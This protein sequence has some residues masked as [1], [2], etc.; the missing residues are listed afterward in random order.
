ML[1]LTG[2][3][4]SGKTHHALD[5]IREC[6][7]RG[8]A[9]ARLL[10]PTATMAEHLRN[11]LARD[12]YLVRTET[13]QTL[14]QFVDALA[15]SPRQVPEAALHHLVRASLEEVDPPAFRA[16]GSMP[17]FQAA[18]AELIEELDGT[19]ESPVQIGERV[20]R[21]HL[22]ADFAAPV[23]EIAAHVREAV[24]HRGME[25]RSDRLR[26]AGQRIGA[27][28]MF[29]VRDVL[30]DGFFRFTAIELDLIRALASAVDVTVTL[31]AWEGAAW[32][33]QALI[34]MGFREEVRFR[35]RQDPRRHLSSA[36]S[37][38]REAEEVA[39][40]VL[41][42]AARGRPFREIGVI[43][44]SRS[45]Y[46]PVLRRAF[47]R[48]AIPAR[49]YFAEPLASH[50]AVRRAAGIVDALLEGWDHEAVLATLRLH[51]ASAS[52]D[53]FEYG[54]L[55]NLPGHGLE[56][57]R[58]LARAS[59][60]EDLIDRLEETDGWRTS[61]ALPAVWAQRLSGLTAVLPS[62][63][64]EDEISHEQ[65]RL[66]RGHAAAE[67]SFRQA[68][69]SVSEVFGDEGVVS[70][71]D[72]WREAR[73][74][75]AATMLRIADNRRNV[76]H[77]M[78]VYEARQ[79]ELPVMFV[80]G[81]NERQFPVH[82]GENP[83]LGDS[84]REA[85]RD[86]GLDLRTSRDQ[87]N[88]E[89][90]LFELATTRATESLTLSYAAFDEGGE[91]K[92]PSFLLERF[93]EQTGLAIA[94]SV[95]VRPRPGRARPLPRSPVVRD[96]SLLERI[97]ATHS[98][99][100][101]SA[102]ERFLQCPFDFFSQKTLRLREMPVPPAER[103][104]ALLEGIIVHAVFAELFRRPEGFD[105][106]EQLF[107]RVFEDRCERAGVPPGYRKQ[108]ARLDLRDALSKFVA[109]NSLP[110]GL[111]SET[112][113]VFQFPLTAEVEVRGRMDRV[114]YH[115]GA[116]PVVIDYKYTRAH[117]LREYVRQNED[118]QRVQAGLYLMGLRERSQERPSG[119][120]F[121]AVRDGPSWKGWH[122]L[123]ELESVLHPVGEEEI[124]HLME[125]A[126]GAARAAA[127]RIR[128][129][130]IAPA[131][132]DAAM[133]TRCRHRDICRVETAPSV[134]VAGGDSR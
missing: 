119:M 61:D 21:R 54:V 16:V 50:P 35:R 88:E 103:L 80:C 74:V 133:C 87:D 67:G 47:E 125:T 63:A 49:F 110:R 77:V 29:G 31:P 19:G 59:S 55:E 83:L 3:T 56:R 132:E 100:S 128:A 72:F 86:E 89:R 97:A 10:T 79:W 28:G 90:F 7:Q 114:D 43:L 75:V 36:P 14:W 32:T 57:L 69:E 33:R 85:L 44:R 127:E 2:P 113:L 115:S 51:P 82:H 81:L 17:G 95:P 111:R 129:G 4:G 1:L 108:T 58:S 52:L 121:C 68:L 99:L 106:W 96:A 20:R 62:P 22:R 130:E 23:L 12:G 46:V 123:T 41:D 30:F 64:I 38:D 6:A 107:E 27:G 66:W 92:L 24:T 76:V 65:A 5:R 40:L 73:A 39:R 15:G 53:Q 70:L 122:V 84:A 117:N 120:L 98:R 93:R 102:L 48:F 60:L 18:V 118:G 26:R 13:V 91:E 34:T 11:E 105:G 124:E 126:A 71:S 42:H 25:L 78:D 134:Q 104:D 131:P 45:P 112:E 94:R 109:L 116:G 9:D 37:A 8:A 101:P